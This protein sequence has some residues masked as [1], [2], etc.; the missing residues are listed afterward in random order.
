MSLIGKSSSDFSSCHINVLCS[1]LHNVERYMRH[2]L[3]SSKWISLCLYFLW[4]LNLLT[5][6]RAT[7]P[8]IQYH[9]KK[10][11]NE[12]TVAQASSSRVLGAILYAGGLTLTAV[13]APLWYLPTLFSSESRHNSNKLESSSFQYWAQSPSNLRGVLR[14][15][16]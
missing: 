13:V 6:W 7:P 4:N 16:R 10:E 15:G 5:L 3:Q 11:R 2:S 14:E 8:I 9:R 12:V 1:K